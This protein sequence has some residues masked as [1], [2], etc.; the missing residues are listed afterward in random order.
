MANS[1]I[2][3][4]NISVFYRGRVKEKGV[5]ICH[6]LVIKTSDLKMDLNKKF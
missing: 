5:I 3:T 4:L 1:S 6:N 2:S